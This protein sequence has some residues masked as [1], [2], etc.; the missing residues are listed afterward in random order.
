MLLL[1]PKKKGWQTVGGGDFITDQHLKIIILA[2]N[3]KFRQKETAALFSAFR[4]CQNMNTAGHRY[5]NALT[6]TDRWKIETP[7]RNL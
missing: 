5:E 2:W 3:G 7:G 1:D 4:I 6:M